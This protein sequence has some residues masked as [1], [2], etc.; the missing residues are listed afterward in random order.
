MDIHTLL[1]KQLKKLLTGDVRNEKCA[2]ARIRTINDTEHGNA[3]D[4]SHP[5]NG[6]HNVVLKALDKWIK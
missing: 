6:A 2:V 4:H 5:P 1:I 3:S